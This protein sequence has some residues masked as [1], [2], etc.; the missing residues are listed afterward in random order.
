MARTDIGIHSPVGMSARS[1]QAAGTFRTIGA[2]AIPGAAG[3]PARALRRCVPFV[4]L[5]QWAAHANNLAISGSAVALLVLSSD[6]PGSP[7]LCRSAAGT[8]RAHERLPS[9]VAT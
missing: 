9:E 1:L 5:D 4:V 7:G 6:H 8:S 2:P 3:P